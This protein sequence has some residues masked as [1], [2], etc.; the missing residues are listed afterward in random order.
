MLNITELSQ[1]GLFIPLCRA[2]EVLIRTAHGPIGYS[3]TLKE[4][5]KDLNITRQAAYDRI[6]VFKKLFPD[7]WQEFQKLQKL[8]KQDRYK[9]RFKRK[10]DQFVGISLFSEIIGNTKPIND[11]DDC[12]DINNCMDIKDCMDIKE[13][14]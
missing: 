12:N 9:L 13:R 4:A 10:S 3:M 14:F 1:K 7:A 8:S 2:V 11:Y 5:A 6:K